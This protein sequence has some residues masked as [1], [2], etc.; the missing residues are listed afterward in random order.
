VV[1][2]EPAEGGGIRLVVREDRVDLALVV[3]AIALEPLGQERT[4]RQ[5]ERPPARERGQPTGADERDLE[6]RG[7]ISHRAPEDATSGADRPAW[8]AAPPLP[9]MA[10]LGACIGSYAARHAS[11][12][13]RLR[14]EQTTA[15][16]LA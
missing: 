11:D 2:E 16:L 7:R 1:D 12:A 5:Q 15:S 10:S 14:P 13:L 8:T 3:E 6:V 4:G 9:P